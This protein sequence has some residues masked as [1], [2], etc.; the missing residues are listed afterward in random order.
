MR[1]TKI[2]WAHVTWNPWRGCNPPAKGSRECLRNSLPPGTQL[3][4]RNAVNSLY[5]RCMPIIG[6]LWR[7]LRGI[8]VRAGLT[9]ANKKRLVLMYTSYLR[10]GIEVLSTSGPLVEIDTM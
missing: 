2:S 5:L 8:R 10:D 6:S 7:E 9:A 3:G 4:Y 1:E